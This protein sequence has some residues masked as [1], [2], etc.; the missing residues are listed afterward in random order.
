[1][2]SFLVTTSVI[3]ITFLP[4]V[5]NG[6][7]T[8]SGT[9]Y[10]ADEEP[11]SLAT[12]VL[13]NS[14][15]NTI[16]DGEVADVD[17]EFELNTDQ[18][19]RY[20]LRVSMVGFT[21][22]HSEP[23][24]LSESNPN[25]DFE[26]I[27]LQIGNLELESLQVTA[28]RPY[29]VR[30]IDRTVLN[31][32]DRVSTA[33]A[34][35]L[36]I[37]EQAPG[38]IVNRQNNTITMLG[39]DGVNVMI[40]GKEQYMPPDALLNYLEGLDGSNIRNI[41]LI[42]TPPASLD[43][44]GNAGF[45]NIELKEE[46][47]RGFNG[48]TSVSSGYG[49]GEVGNASLNLNYRASKLNISGN[50]SYLR[51][52]QEQFTTLFRQTGSGTNLREVFL[53][54]DRSP[55]Q[56]NH[57]ARF[58]LDYNLAEN[59]ILGVLVSGY[60]NRWDM[61]AVNDSRFR[62][63]NASD[64]LLTSRNSEDNDWNHLHTNLNLSHIFEGGSSLNLD[65]DYLIYDNKNPVSYDLTYFDTSGNSL[66][67]ELVFSRK[68][69]PFDIMVAEADYTRLFGESMKLSTG[70]KFA[71][72]SFENDVLV[73]ENNI[74]LPGFTSQSD[75]EEQIIAA[76]SQLDY[77]VSEK[78]A[79]NVGLRF[80][81]SQTDLNSS[82]GGQVVDR[83]LNRLFPSL[84]LSHDINQQNSLNFSYGKRINRPAFS[85]MAPFVIF[86]TPNT[87]F[88]GNAALQP[89]IAHTFQ[90]GYRYGDFNITAQYSIE[91]SSIVRFQNRFNPGENTQIIVPDNLKEQ[92]IFSTSI[93]FPFRV[94]AWWRMRYSATYTWRE[95]TMRDGPE[96][97][98]FRNNNLALNGSQSFTFGNNFS[99]EISG[100]Y[101]TQSQVGN[102]RFDPL[103]SLNFGVSKQ[104][105]NSSRLSFNMTDL[106]NTLKRSGVTNLENDDFFVNRT[107]DFSQRTFNL[108]YTFSFG[109]QNVKGARNRDSA[110]EEQQRIN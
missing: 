46:R 110:R 89:A 68:D 19:G 69:T 57:N 106:L 71:Q 103:G 23:F 39:K 15:D 30:E 61:E 74:E 101:Q 62:L 13:L 49:R 77:Q 42:T 92:Q 86:L 21:A 3:L 97:L 84:F 102:V 107:F 7:Y 108:T 73:E 47:E 14:S 85:D 81:H 72:S 79:L 58:S 59:T 27:I 99:A 90:A 51:S 75:L 22:F 56:N 4:N 9:V 105:S 109:S 18:A 25:H 54:S 48:T 80:E 55:T 98:M 67:E 17:G 34:N 11:L 33:G 31:V 45:I 1:M 95:S 82:N 10:D 20:I 28:D 44:E 29:I 104:F 93:A 40:N 36:E 76:Y 41:E 100:F 94:T 88:G 6:Q 96:M 64:T 78:T 38:I 26:S 2:K 83:S 87:S 53:T 24:E 12:I 70:L 16:I 66:R 65:L 5:S 37:L 35:T 52:G 50:Y 32:E 8:V 91:D 63:P 43:A 60:A